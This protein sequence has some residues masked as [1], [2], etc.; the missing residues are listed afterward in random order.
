MNKRI[1]NINMEL[2]NRMTFK[3]VCTFLCTLVIAFALI[4]CS[5][6]VEVKNPS[7]PEELVI[8]SITQGLGGQPENSVLKYEVTLSSKA[9]KAYF[10]K[11]I[12]PILS[13]EIR[14]RL[15][16][17][18]ITVQVNKEIPPSS[19]IKIEGKFEFNTKGLNKEE[20]TKL[21]PNVKAFNVE[22]VTKIEMN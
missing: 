5:R 4:G 11:S 7:S 21:T 18:Q 19:D 15:L 14:S 3:S 8:S 17:K 1:K 9:N 13:E 22:T 2:M 6:S 12:E 10:I 20:I 16:D